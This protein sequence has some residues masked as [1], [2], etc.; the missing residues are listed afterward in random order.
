[1]NN[2]E[3]TIND[4]MDFLIDFKDFVAE[5]FATKEELTTVLN[6]LRDEM[7]AGFYRL[8]NKIDGVEARL[9]KRINDLEQRTFEDTNA[10]TKVTQKHDRRI[11]R[12]EAR[13]GV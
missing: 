10:L 12:L 11:T 3:I 7:H 2:K 5:H 9:T 8:E 4:V 13:V 6:D 1:M